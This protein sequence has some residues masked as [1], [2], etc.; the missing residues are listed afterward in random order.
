MQYLHSSF[1][2]KL[3]AGDVV[4]NVY[5]NHITKYFWLLCYLL[6]NKEI[7]KYQFC[8]FHL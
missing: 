5:F 2:F 3:A 4:V 8:T 7:L 6:F 1:V